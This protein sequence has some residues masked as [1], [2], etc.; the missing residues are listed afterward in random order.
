MNRQVV[1]KKYENR[2]LYDTTHSRYF[3]LEEVAQMV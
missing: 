1:I 3:N 2:R